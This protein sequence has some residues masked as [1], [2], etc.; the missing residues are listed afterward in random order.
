VTPDGRTLVYLSYAN[1]GKMLGVRDL[2]SGQEKIIMQSGYWPDSMGL[3]PDGQQVAVIA[4]EGPGVEESQVLMV[5]PVSGGAPRKLHRIE[6]PWSFLGFAA[7]TPDGTQILCGLRQRG[8]SPQ[9]KAE[10]LLVPAAGGEPKKT[11]LPIGGITEFSFHP[12]GRRVAFD[13]GR[14]RSEVWVIENF[15]PPAK[16]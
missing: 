13:A 10:Y 3:S 9:E 16:Q 8:T 6:K 12:G 4:A 11:V 1:D 15:L 5:I 14:S 2:Q 7:W